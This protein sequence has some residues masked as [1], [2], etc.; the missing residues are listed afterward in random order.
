MGGFEYL[1]DG[2]H[3][4]DAGN[5]I[6]CTYVDFRDPAERFPITVLQKPRRSGTRF[7]AGRAGSRSRPAP[8]PRRRTHQRRR[9]TLRHERLDLLRVYRA[10]RNRSIML[11]AFAS[12]ADLSGRGR[13]A[14]PSCTCRVGERDFPVARSITT[15]LND[16]GARSFF[17]RLVTLSSA[18]VGRW[19]R[20]RPGDRD[21]DDVLQRRTSALGARRSHAGR[22]LRRGAGSVTASTSSTPWVRTGSSRR[23]GSSGRSPT[24]RQQM[25]RPACSSV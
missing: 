17:A 24:C 6:A 3:V 1:A 22:G 16:G 11:D 5:L 10:V 14:P 9:V 15:L 2:H 4:D 13:R 19:V 7:R 23:R 12:G 20:G 18:R 21:L 8:R 25:P